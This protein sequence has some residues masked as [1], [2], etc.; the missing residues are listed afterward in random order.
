MGLVCLSHDRFPSAAALLVFL[1]AAT[2]SGQSATS[3]APSQQPPIRTGVNLVRVDVYPARDGKPVLD[4]RQEDF[5]VFEDSSPQ[6]VDSFEHVV[7]QPAGP[8][9]TRVEPSSQR[10]MLQA[11]ANPRSRVF[12]IFL[13]TPNVSIEGAHHINEPLIKLIDRVLGPDD[14]VAVMTPAMSASQLVL[15]RKTQVIEESLRRNWAWGTRFTMQFDEREEMYIACFASP[16][17]IVSPLAAEMIH[18]KRERATLEALQDLVRYLHAVRE[19][20]KAILTV[21]EGW[22][23]Y[24]ESQEMLKLRKD[25]I[26]GT[27][28]PVP[29]R[30]PIVVGPTGQPVRND[31]RQNTMGMSRTECDSER[32]RLA[33]MDNERFF[34]DLL[35]DANRANASFYPIDPRGLVAFDT[36]IRPMFGPSLTLVGDRASLKSRQD[37]MHEL[38]INTDGLAVM[39]SNDLDAG[40][41]R[42][43]DDL[44]S[45]YLLGYYSTNTKLDGR[46]RQIRVRVKRP[47][48]QVRARRGY[49]A[50]TAEEAARAL[51]ADEPPDGATSALTAA[52]GTL[53]RTRPDTSF[54]INAATAG[55]SGIVWVAGEVLAGG[56]DGTNLSGG[57]TVDVD[58]AGDQDSGSA[59]VTLKPGERTF[60][61]S[62]KLASTGR[63]LDVRARLTPE[64]GAALTDNVRLEVGPAVIRPL[65]F[66]RGPTTGNRMLPAADF[67]FSRMERLR[68]EVP[69]SAGAKPGAARLLDRAGNPLEIPVAV[70][71]RADEASGQQWIVADLTLAPLAPGDY[72]I[73]IPFTSADAERRVLTAIRLTR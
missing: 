45:Y 15:G 2:L 33:M 70:T 7:I 47:G 25:P 29:G 19:E 42:I 1:A 46:F 48:V 56:R 41:K 54:R 63:Q 50:A 4:L 62:V 10:Q 57:S 34:R 71:Q 11:A 23:R 6:Q 36:P 27:Q 65:L 28:E 21:T 53:D 40:L 32:M 44:T 69:V 12:V 68:I 14:L 35:D 39:D 24:R 73:E 18:R 38:A 16:T 8:Q 30:D 9:A 5:E 72:A 58:V 43:S 51:K 64:G 67:R 31:P 20:R 61:T 17:S 59:R 49:R 13:D 26:T 22:L 66:R 60:L 37:A 52:L 3:P 55:T